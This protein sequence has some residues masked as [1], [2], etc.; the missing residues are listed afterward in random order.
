VSAPDCSASKLLSGLSGQD[1]QDCVNEMLVEKG[2]TWLEQ[3]ACDY[4]TDGIAAAFCNSG[5]FQAATKVV[6]TFANKYIEKPICDAAKAV[7]DAVVKVAKTTWNWFTG[8]FHWLALPSPPLV[9]KTAPLAVAMNG[10]RM[11]IAPNVMIAS[12]DHSCTLHRAVFKVDAGYCRYYVCAHSDGNLDWTVKFTGL[13]GKNVVPFD[14][15]VRV[16]VS[17]NLYPEC[18]GAMDYTRSLEYSDGSPHDGS[19]TIP[20]SGIGSQS[21]SIEFWCRSISNEPCDLTY[22]ELLYQSTS[23]TAAIEMTGAAPLRADL[24]NSATGTSGHQ[25]CDGQDSNFVQCPGGSGST[26]CQNQLANKVSDTGCGAFYAFAC[27]NC[28]VDESTACAP[29]WNSCDFGD[30]TF[31][32]PKSLQANLAAVP[33]TEK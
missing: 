27:Y 5:L 9:S 14:Y 22:T 10:S 21:I 15:T 28:C 11:A 30:S 7:E 8:L 13:Q 4:L 16:G 29:G 12:P 20:A 31:T 23:R 6:N 25:F 3:A 26:I 32:C 33:A 2:E 24:H 18:G 1:L 19:F 17:D